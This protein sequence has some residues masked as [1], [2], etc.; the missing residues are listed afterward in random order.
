MCGDILQSKMYEVQK[1]FNNSIILVLED[2]HEKI[3][4][5]KGIGFG[6]RPGDVISENKNIDKIF[7]IQKPENKNKFTELLSKVDED[8]VA[9]SE[10]I[11]SMIS[12][13][14]SEDLDESIHISL[15][16]HI[17]FTLKR[18]KESNEITNPFLIETEVLFKKEYDLAKK[19]VLILEKRT[20]ISIPEGETGFI[21]LHIH[22]AR[23][24]GTLSNTIKY[25]FLANKIAEFIESS[26]NIKLDKE[27]LDYARFIVHLRFAIE[28]L[29]NN[30]PI[31]NELLSTIKR[32]YKSSYK[33]A[34]T[35]GKIIEDNLNVSV[36][37]DEIGY[38][39]IHLRNLTENK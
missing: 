9:V 32:K 24:K 28:R 4:F 1:I 26:L 20:G 34:Q 38:I 15:T 13:E 35:I 22:S 3:L 10:E 14:L 5:G 27:S 30:S 21:T 11:I 25:T 17:F 6:R 19:A 31:K 33:L 39:A 37:P 12:A 8:I 29:L 16:D 36:V 18:L 7:T 23:N 2:N